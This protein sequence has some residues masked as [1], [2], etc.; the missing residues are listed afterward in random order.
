MGLTVVVIPILL[1]NEQFRNIHVTLFWSLR[2]KSNSPEGLLGKI[3]LPYKIGDG[4]EVRYLTRFPP[5]S[6]RHVATLSGSTPDT[7][8]DRAERQKGPK[9]CG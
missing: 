1:A 4:Q 6:S 8:D 2:W 3:F 9:S 7:Q 5:S